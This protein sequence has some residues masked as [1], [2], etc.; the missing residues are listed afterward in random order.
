MKSILLL[1][2]FTLLSVSNASEKIK[3]DLLR[4]NFIH[5]HGTEVI[6]LERE[7]EEDDEGNLS[8]KIRPSYFLPEFYTTTNKTPNVTW[9]I[10]INAGSVSVLSN[11]SQIPNN[12]GTEFFL[13]GKTIFN[14]R[15]Y[16]KSLIKNKH[17]IRLLYAPLQYEV[18]L[19]NDQDI[20]FQ[21]S[22]FLA[23]EPTEALYKFNSY[24][25]SYI[26]HFNRNKKVKF[27]LGFTAK[28]RDAETKLTQQNQ[29][30]SFT[31]VGFVPLIHIGAEIQV[32]Q[33]LYL[34]TEVEGSW[35][36]Q[37]YAIDSRLSL[38][39]H[40]NNNTTLG[41]GV[42]YLDGGADVD[43]VNTFARIFFGYLR[44]TYTFPQKNKL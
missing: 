41:A 17:E 16:L 4:I 7:Y 27:R 29:E 5:G 35:A 24:R 36:P 28:I 13:D 12:T 14:Y 3:S 6:D 8:V 30:E 19:A 21:D 11:F 37:G 44:V 1:L 26:F 33:K 2:T 18:A 10:D 15:V 31:N 32:T 40:I 23:T 43:S 25:L 42:G 39:Y 20:L 9:T 38:N 22:L 34:D